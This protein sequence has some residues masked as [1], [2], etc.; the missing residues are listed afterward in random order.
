LTAVL[1]TEA[2]VLQNLVDAVSTAHVLK[3]AAELGLID[4][5][6]QG[7]RDPAQLASMCSTDL[8]V[9]VLLL[10]ALSC[11]GVICRDAG[12]RYELAVDG[13][14]LVTTV[15]RGWSHLAEVVRSGEPVVAAH[16]VPGA[17]D[18]YP[19]LVQ[20][21][22]VLLAPA[23]QRAAQLLVGS[24]VDVLDVGAGAAPWSIALTQR[25]LSV[26]V[27]ALDLPAVLVSTRRAVGASGVGDRFDYLPGDMFTSQLP[28]SAYDLAL[29]A[30]V[31]HLFDEAQIRALLRRLWQAVRPGG[32]LAIID[33]LA[34]RDE[35]ASLSV[36][37]YA[38]G[39]RLR[40]SCGA[41]HSLAAYQAW[42]A[43]AGFGP[44]QVEPLSTAP[45]LH[46]LACRRK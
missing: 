26:R 37:L 18:L 43:D 31:C 40:T 14:P 11:L 19:D 16:T 5:L 45:S 28:Q 20:S 39:L 21:L 7:A 6:S 35:V 24:G 33:V 2:P 34:P 12:G 13:L 3:A 27:T 41:V 17:A 46:L 22:S 4:C 32:L 1:H 42:A 8:S 25:S 29:L 36:S 9:T 15:D 38:L 10:D 23:A 44:A 30:N